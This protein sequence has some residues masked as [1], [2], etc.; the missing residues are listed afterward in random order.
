MKKQVSIECSRYINEEEFVGCLSLRSD[1]LHF[2]APLPKQHRFIIPLHKILGMTTDQD[3]LLCLTDS[4]VIYFFSPRRQI[5]EFV[6]KIRAVQSKIEAE[7]QSRQTMTLFTQTQIGT[8]FNR[9]RCSLYL[10]TQMLTLYIRD[11]DTIQI[12][13]EDITDCRLHGVYRRVHL[14]TSERTWQLF[15]S[16]ALKMYA[17]ITILLN[18]EQHGH[19]LVNSWTD[20]FRRD[21]KLTWKAFIIQTERKLHIYPSTPWQGFLN[22]QPVHF[23][24]DKISL[25][26]FQ[27]EFL[28]FQI[29][30]RIMFLSEH[31][32]MGFWF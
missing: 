23:E 18:P 15:G 6:Q 8:L 19:H 20:Q 26:E 22:T 10:T 11:E 13:L 7:H 14:S 31:K 27:N 4:G 2:E 1:H 12:P 24:I 30:D 16:E 21:G 17:L 28:R 3:T 5:E 25:L 9:N 32:N 29:L